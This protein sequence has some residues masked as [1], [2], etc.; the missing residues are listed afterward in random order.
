LW[1]MLLILCPY[2]F[3]LT[4]FGTP[5]F[6]P[7]CTADSAFTRG[8]SLSR[9]LPANPW[10]QKG[11]RAGLF[12]PSAGVCWWA[13][14]ALG[15]LPWWVKCAFELLLPN[16]FSPLLPQLDLYC[17]LSLSPLLHLYSTQ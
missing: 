16:F 14:F 8:H 7:I 11:I 1:H 5:P 13:I 15:S 3:L 9:L 2:S 17:N 12:Q 4:Y 6:T 10:A